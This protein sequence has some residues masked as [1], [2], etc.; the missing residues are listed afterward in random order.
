MTQ[1]HWQI[2]SL[3]SFKKKQAELSVSKPGTL[4]TIRHGDHVTVVVKVRAYI[5]AGIV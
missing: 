2:T 4:Q 5:G 1:T 3:R